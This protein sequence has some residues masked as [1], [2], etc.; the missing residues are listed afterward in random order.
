MDVVPVEI[1]AAES[2]VEGAKGRSSSRLR[3]AASVLRR[4]LAIAKEGDNDVVEGPRTKEVSTRDIE[5]K[6][7]DNDAEEVT[8]Y[9]IRHGKSE[10][11]EVQDEAPMA[12]LSVMFDAP[13]SNIGQAQAL[14]AGQAV[15]ESTKSSLEEFKSRV[16]SGEIEFGSSPMNRAYTTLML[17]LAGMGVRDLSKPVFMMNSMQELNGYFAAPDL[18]NPTSSRG[19]SSGSNLSDGDAESPDPRTRGRGRFSASNM[20]SSAPARAFIHAGIVPMIGGKAPLPRRLSMASREHERIPGFDKNRRHFDVRK[21]LYNAAMAEQAQTETSTRPY[22]TVKSWAWENENASSIFYDFTTKRQAVDANGRLTI[23]GA[24]IVNRY[25]P[26]S[27]Q[28]GAKDLFDLANRNTL[29][30]ALVAGHS[31]WFRSFMRHSKAGKLVKEKY[32][33][34]IPHD[35]THHKLRN[36]QLVKLTIKKHKIDVVRR[37]RGKFGCADAKEVKEDFYSVTAFEVVTPGFDK[38]EERKTQ[39]ERE[40]PQV[41]VPAATSRGLS[42][43][44]GGLARGRS[45]SVSS[46]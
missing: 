15:A 41:E 44:I 7:G 16:L 26:D 40:L 1:R 8:V 12:S 32:E 37:A 33:R 35:P 5:V 38:T 20:M 11:N 36:A 42:S 22:S 25:S 3:G 28:I 21:N 4:R 39:Y 30:T 46:P 14:E 17:F 34:E 2:A 19:L 9:F 24:A 27:D 31:E 13:L 43:F 29:K 10:Q 18:L 23:E 45:S 6:M